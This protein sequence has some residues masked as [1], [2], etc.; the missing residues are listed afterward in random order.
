MK[1]LDQIEI[2]SVSGAD[3]SKFL[4]LADMV[5]D[6]WNGFLAGGKDGWGQDSIPDTELTCY[7]NDPIR[8]P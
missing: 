3:W 5:I 2:E 1:E 7:A 6:L 4:F 8:W